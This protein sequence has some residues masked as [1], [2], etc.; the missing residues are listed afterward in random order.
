MKNSKMDSDWSTHFTGFWLVDFFFAGKHKTVIN[1]DKTNRNFTPD[2]ILRL[3]YAKFIFFQNTWCYTIFFY[4]I[5]FHSKVI[6]DHLTVLNSNE[7]YWGT[8]STHIKT[9]IITIM[10]S[11]VLTVNFCHKFGAFKALTFTWFTELGR[12]TIVY[13]KMNTCYTITA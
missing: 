5:H 12:N 1:K 10:T 8:K 7:R 6:N 13:I 11:A 4:S 9:M 3:F 2:K